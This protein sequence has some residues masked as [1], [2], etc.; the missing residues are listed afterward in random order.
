VSEVLVRFG[1]RQWALA[2]GREL[3]FGRG[4][5]RDIRFGH[6][7]LDDHVSRLAGTLGGAD[8]HVLV[9]NDSATR[10]VLVQ[11]PGSVREIEP[12]EAVLLPRR[13]DFAVLVLGGYD[14]RYELRVATGH[15]E[16]IGPAGPPERVEPG[17]RPTVSAGPVRL[18]A[19]QRRVLVALCE[20]LLRPSGPDAGPATYRQI[21]ARLERSPG[22]VRNVLKEVRETLAAAGVP[23]LLAGPDGE[24]G[25]YDFRRPLAVWALRAAVV[26][27]GDV[28]PPGG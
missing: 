24:D 21:G 10:P 13:R 11:V 23:G 15:A 12:G 19:A 3:T 6:D 8:A 5:D 2:P 25:A 28:E 22:Y 14:V 1:G 9:R 18:T 4:R 7:P 26:R 27:P 17:S 16:P 20:P